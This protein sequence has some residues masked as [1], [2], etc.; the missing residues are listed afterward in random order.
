[1]TATVDGG[2]RI[3]TA[4]SGKALPSPRLPRV[5]RPPRGVEGVGLRAP[6]LPAR[7]VPGGT[8]GRLVEEEQLGVPAGAHHRMARAPLEVQHAGDPALDLPALDEH[9]LAV[10]QAATVAHQGAVRGIG[11]E[12]L[13]RQHPGVPVS[14]LLGDFGHQRAS[15]KRDVRTLLLRRIHAWMDHHVRGVGRRRPCCRP[16]APRSRPPRPTPSPG[17]ATSAWRWRPGRPRAPRPTTSRPPRA[18]GRCCSVRRA[19]PRGCGS[20]APPPRRAAAGAPVGRRPRRRDAAPGGARDA[21]AVRRLARRLRPARQGLALR[22]RARRAARA[23]RARRAVRAPVERR[24]LD[25]RR[26]AGARPPGARPGRRRARLREPAPRD[27]ARR[28]APRRAR[29]PRDR[30]DRLAPAA[31][32]GRPAP[33]RCPRRPARS[34]AGPSACPR[35]RHG[36]VR[37]PVHGRPVAADLHAARG[38]PPR[39]TEAPQPASQIAPSRTSTGNVFRPP[40]PIVPLTIPATGLNAPCGPRTIAPVRTS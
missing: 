8:R 31:T 6:A 40:A 26:R 9:A 34:P 2:V 19:S 3:V 32:R 10:D 23:R 13:R 11:I 20:A 33:P 30:A 36:D 27:R 5:E 7:P 35:A 24:V 37:A 39:A 17:A 28:A 4:A 22:G 14:V 16:A 25:Q 12:R 21:A 15:N 29:A 38:E 18:R 1:M